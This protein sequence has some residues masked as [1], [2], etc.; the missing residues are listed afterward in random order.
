MT[1][2]CSFCRLSAAT[3]ILLAGI[4]LGA[5]AAAA[6]DSA[7]TV[8]EIAPGIFVHQGV[9]AEATP[10]NLGGIANIGFIIG[11]DSIAVID[12]GGSLREGKALLAAIRQISPLPVRY[13]IN[14]HF[15]PDHIFG[16]GAFAASH[17]EVIAHANLPRSLAARAGDYLASARSA[18]GQ[19]FLGT[20]IPNPK[21]LVGKTDDIDLGHRR[22]H[23]TAFP[24]AHTDADLTVYDEKTGTIFAGDLLFMERIP[25]IDGSVLGWLKAID[26]L[27]R[28]KAQRVVPGH[29]PVSAPWPAAL[30]DEE[31]YLFVIATETRKALANGESLRQATA[32]VGQ[33]ERPNWQLFDAYNERNVTAAYTELEWEE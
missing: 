19:S 11:D 6:D 32:T 24:P 16:N 9:H 4:W 33:S 20:E 15:H 2:A 14:T 29:G 8:T 25:S 7:L 18:M 30:D 1:I 27:R 13:V 10:E 31:R 5:T 17:P 23:L 21:R 28:V 26:K 12:T 22:L 3:M